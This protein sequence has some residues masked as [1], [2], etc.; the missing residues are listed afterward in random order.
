MQYTTIAS[1]IPTTSRGLLR[2][3][4]IQLRRLTRNVDLPVKSGEM[5]LVLGRP[6]SGCST[7]LRTIS[8]N[9]ENMTIEMPAL[10][11]YNSI[12]Q[13]QMLR[14]FQGEVVYNPE[15]DLHIPHLAV[16]QT[17]EFAAAMRTPQSPSRRYLAG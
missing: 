5:L 16:R 9:L 17:L 8:G 11:H 4:N 7:L 10:I 14:E 13:L 2:Q 6:G 15:S 1:V 3:R 12:P